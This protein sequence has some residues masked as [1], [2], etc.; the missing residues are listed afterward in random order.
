MN[1]IQFE[2]GLVPTKVVQEDKAEYI[3][4]LNLSREDD[5]MQ[6]FQLFMLKEHIKN[7]QNE[8]IEYP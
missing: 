7:L 2:F 5:S 6:P 4:A 3:E 8:I 1:H